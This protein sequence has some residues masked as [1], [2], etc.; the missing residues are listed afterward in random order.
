MAM[1]APWIKSNKRR[2]IRGEV[3]P[4]DKSTIVSIFPEEITERKPTIEPGIFHIGAGS[5]AK[6]A[7]LTIGPSSWWRDIDEDQPLLE[8][9]CSSIQIA[10]AFVKDYSN[11]LVACD[12]DG[13]MPGLF[14]V[15]GEH[16]V[17]AI[18]KTFGERL[19][20]AS[21]KQ[22]NWYEKL[23][24]IADA[25]WARS[26][27]NPLAIP[28]Q[29]RLAARELQMKNKSWMGDYAHLELR[30]CPACGHMVN[31]A[32]PV[33]S[34]CKTVVDKKKAEELKLEFAR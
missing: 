12:M 34:N 19:I 29:A 28:D 33:C 24:M 22:R 14:F 16:S 1:G 26:Q 9:P 2:I 13:C 25:L 31:P 23:V 3:N 7:V 6:P 15:P 4:L 21:R 32:F 17:D 27:G 18:K 11:G 20:A 8:I 30:N 5:L 10:D